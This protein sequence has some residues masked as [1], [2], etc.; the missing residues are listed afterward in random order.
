M[1][2]QVRYVDSRHAYFEHSLTIADYILPAYTLVDLQAGV[3]R[4]PYE[5]TAFARNLSN[6]R[7]QQGAL[8]VGIP[9]VSIERPHAPVGISFSGA[10]W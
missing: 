1:G 4:G 6:E 10:H 2:G 9:F 3:R 7:A 8:N 5:V